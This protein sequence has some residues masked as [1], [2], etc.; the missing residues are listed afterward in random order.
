MAFKK[1]VNKYSSEGHRM[2]CTRTPEADTTDSQTPDLTCTPDP[3]R[4]GAHSQ[5][6]G[7]DNV[8]QKPNG[9]ATGWYNNHHMYS[10][11]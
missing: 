1:P 9:K 7:V 3:E 11:Q 8:A 4:I 5:G 6:V 2:W 10:Q